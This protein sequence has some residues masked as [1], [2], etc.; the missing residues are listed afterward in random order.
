MIGELPSFFLYGEPQTFVHPD[1]VH[2]EDL[3]ERSRPS[4]WT[5]RPHFHD[6]LNHLIVITEGGGRIRFEVTQIAFEAPQLIV[7]PARLIHGFDW[8]PESAGMVLTIA[9][10]HLAE[11][12]RRHREFSRLF[13]AARCA[14]LSA[15]N[16]AALTTALAS[17]RSELSWAGLGHSAA[18]EAALLTTMV[19]ALR[20]IR[21]AEDSGESGGRRATLIARF[22]E[23]IERR[24]ALR[25]SVETYARELA[26]SATT[27]RETC[28]A[29]GTSPTEMRDKR[30]IL[31]AQRLLAYSDKSIAEIGY[32]I[33]IS[34]PPY[35]SRFFT[36]NC[37]CSPEAWRRQIRHRAPGDQNL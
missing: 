17:L 30:A 16:V 9:N 23:L 28:A 27:L 3:A 5:I 11:M 21:V 6:D 25:E 18:I 8:Y 31:E 32:A 7:V 37:G 34:D 14:P 35:F 22:R 24:Y 29:I 2:V 20:M 15:G 26:V 1:F 33:G 4:E 12:Q 36:R 19:Q 10:P 13:D